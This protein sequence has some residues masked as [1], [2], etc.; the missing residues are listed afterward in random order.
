MYDIHTSNFVCRVLFS[1]YFQE[2]DEHF[3]LIQEYY[4]SKLS[5]QGCN[6]I[7]DIRNGWPFLQVWFSLQQPSQKPENQWQH[8]TIRGHEK[9]ALG[10]V[11]H[12]GSPSPMQSHFL[13]TLHIQ[14]IAPR[15]FKIEL[16]TH[17][18]TH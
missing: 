13:S 18:P 8:Q 15:E 14:P 4:P 6:L 1:A 10:N 17:T 3:F 9:P 7:W 11:Y 16:F 5:S 12:T 2:N